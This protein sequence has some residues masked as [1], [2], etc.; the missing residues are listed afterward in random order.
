[1]IFQD[2]AAVSKK[3]SRLLKILPKQVRGFLKRVQ[4]WSTFGGG[5]LPAVEM[6]SE[7]VQVLVPGVSAEEISSLLL[8]E[9]AP[10]AGYIRDGHYTLDMRTVQEEDLRPLASSIMNVI[11]NLKGI[12]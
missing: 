9:E 2:R 5:A 4:S 8:S 1:M 7:G 11:T 10:V 6:E 3:A 12:G